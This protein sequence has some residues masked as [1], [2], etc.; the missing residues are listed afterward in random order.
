[1][2]STEQILKEL[3]QR[4]YR[5]SMTRFN[6]Q[7][8]QYADNG[9]LEADDGT[10]LGKLS[11]KYDS[12][13]IFNKYGNYGSKYSSTSIFNKYGNYGSKYSAQSPINPYT[14]TPPKVYLG[15]QFTGYLTTNKY[16]ANSIPV[17]LFLFYVMNQMGSL[18]D[19]LDDF[20]DLI[21]R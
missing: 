11:N 14:T 13:S 7:I 19:R 6:F 10:F 3:I 18:D 12:E 2:S 16:L 21:S 8:N 5:E 15:G 9:Y 20:L 4:L 1:M 17:D